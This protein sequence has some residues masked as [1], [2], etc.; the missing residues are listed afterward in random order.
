MI[1]VQVR[2]EDIANVEGAQKWIL[3]LLNK[4]EKERE[5]CFAS[6]IFSPGE[7][8]IPQPREM[9]LRGSG[10]DS[11]LLSSPQKKNL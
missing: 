4:V 5:E 9:I 10:I 8:G 3:S 7:G 11:C 2:F 1:L 6:G